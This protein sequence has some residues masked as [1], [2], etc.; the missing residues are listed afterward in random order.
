MI[1]NIQLVIL[2]FQLMQV[3]KRSSTDFQYRFSDIN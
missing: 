1:V 3:I 2:S